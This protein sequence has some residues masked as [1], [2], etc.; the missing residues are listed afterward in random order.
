MA[1][2]Y[3]ALGSI[4]ERREDKTAA[5]LLWRDARQLFEKV[6]VPDKVRELSSKLSRA[7]AP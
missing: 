4:F 1:N 2:A 3:M 6:G 7:A 5:F